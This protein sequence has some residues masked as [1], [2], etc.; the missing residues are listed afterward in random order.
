[1]ATSCNNVSRL[2]RARSAS[3]CIDISAL[4][5]WVQGLP[6]TE[7]GI[8]HIASRW[9]SHR[10]D[11]RVN[12]MVWRQCSQLSKGKIVYSGVGN[13]DICI[14]WDGSEAKFYSLLLL[15]VFQKKLLKFYCGPLLVVT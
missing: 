4:R 5:T 13:L 9:L 8:N 7:Q 2:V 3:N 12:G 14:A 11:R 10:L 6:C 1:M 15:L